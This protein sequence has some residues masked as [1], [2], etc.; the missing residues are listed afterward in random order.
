M[1]QKNFIGVKV[2]KANLITVREAMEKGYKTSKEPL[3][4]LG[5]EV[6]YEDGYKSFSPKDVFEKAYIEDDLHSD[7]VL[8]GEFEPYQQRVISEFEE[9]KLKY[10]AL[11]KFLNDIEKGKLQPIPEDALQLLKVQATTM[12]MYLNILKLRILKFKK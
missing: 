4:H 3:E 1:E 6:E 5:Y 12:K 11:D 2:V 7:I 10:L 9:L 8:T